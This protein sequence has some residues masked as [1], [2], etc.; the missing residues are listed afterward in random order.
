MKEKKLANYVALV[1]L[2]G[3]VMCLNPGFAQV[4]T[5]QAL[6]DT[7]KITYNQISQSLGLFVFPS[8][9]QSQGKQKQDEFECYKWAMDQSGIDPQN[10]PKI[11]V[12]E[13]T[14]PTGGAVVG[15]AGGAAAGAA[16]GAIA[17]DTGKGA[18]IGATLGA[19]R[20]RRA[21]QQAQAQYNQKAHSEAAAQE[22]AMLDKFKKAFSAC[23]EGKGYTIK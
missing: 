21:G 2:L 20:G 6:P 1:L 13:S 4:P 14:G 5:M 16:I 17:G 19:L 7:S 9:N 10:I 23:M 11:E 3:F 15:A 22:S 18:A 8:K 12:E